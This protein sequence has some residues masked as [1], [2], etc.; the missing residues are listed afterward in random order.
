MFRQDKRRAVYWRRRPWVIALRLVLFVLTLPLAL[1]TVAGEKAG[2]LLG[3]LDSA[4]PSVEVRRCCGK[5]R[6]HKPGCAQANS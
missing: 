3:W 6:G 4:A 2:D 1:L 5:P